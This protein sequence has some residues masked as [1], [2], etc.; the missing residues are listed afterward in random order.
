MKQ[1]IFILTVFSFVL[2]TSCDFRYPYANPKTYKD[3]PAWNLVKALDNKNWKR[4][5]EEINKNPKLVN[6]TDP[7]FGNSI[8]LWAVVN[9]NEIAVDLLLKAGADV[10]KSD[11]KGDNPL[12]IFTE[13]NKTNDKI[14]LNLL[15]HQ[16]ENDSIT[17]IRRNEALVLASKNT[18]S[19]VKL[20]IRYNANP[21]YRCEN[22]SSFKNNSPLSMAIVQQK[23]DIVAYYLGVLNVNP[24][25]GCFINHQGDT[26]YS[27]NQLLEEDYNEALKQNNTDNS[28]KIKMIMDFLIKKGFSHSQHKSTFRSQVMLITCFSLTRQTT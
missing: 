2:F 4:A 19:Q 20:L 18:L 28:Q 11:F 1:L 5:K 16:P 27:I 23:Y 24:S 22:D 21:E 12:S 8:L 10:N 7:A 9:E 13:L 25:S 14:L 26:T 3:T 15:R 17:I 6:Y